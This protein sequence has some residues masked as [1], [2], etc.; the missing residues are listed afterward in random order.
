V[1]LF[2][3]A[4]TCFVSVELPIHATY[5]WTIVFTQGDEIV[6]QELHRTMDAATEAAGEDR[7][8]G[9]ICRIVPTSSLPS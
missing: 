8:D 9:L 5:P 3:S 2:S 4:H 7:E 6:D 1:T